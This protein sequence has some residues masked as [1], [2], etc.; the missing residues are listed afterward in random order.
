MHTQ[1]KRRCF[2]GRSASHRSHSFSRVC[3]D[4]TLFSC[5]ISPYSL[6]VVLKLF[7]TQKEKEKRNT[8][9]RIWKGR[10]QGRQERERKREKGKRRKRRSQRGGEKEEEERNKCRQRCRL[11]T[12]DS[13]TATPFTRANRRA[14]L[15]TKPRW[16][17]SSCG[18]GEKNITVALVTIGSEIPRWQFSQHE[19]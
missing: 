14:A 17:P 15:S 9:K 3:C 7:T 18:I 2:C 19:L 13:S 11:L 5:S 6:A 1:V 4:F 10:R 12:T 16:S 8:R